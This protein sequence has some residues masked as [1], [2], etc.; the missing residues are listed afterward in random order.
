MIKAFFLILL[1]VSY[2]VLSANIEL[3]DVEN[4][5]PQAQYIYASSLH[6]SDSSKAKHWFTIAALQNHLKSADWI[7]YNTQYYEDPLLFVLISTYDNQKQ[8]LINLNL[9][10]ETRKEKLKQ[11]RDLGNRGDIDTQYLMWCL[12]VNDL[13]ISKAEAYTWLKQAAGNGHPRALFSL[14]LLYHYGYIVP[15]EPKRT[16]R[17]MK[18]AYLAGFDLAQ[19]FLMHIQVSFD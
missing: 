5:E 13:G 6:K 15:K 9:S 3:T 14:G 17:L 11:F 18:Q 10:K 19:A 1:L 2:E 8:K 4:G 16:I 7:K 12:Y